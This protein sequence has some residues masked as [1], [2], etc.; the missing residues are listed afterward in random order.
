M[1]RLPL[2]IDSPA[3]T[4]HPSP[5]TLSRMY[6][7]RL[8]DIYKSLPSIDTSTQL[9][10]FLKVPEFCNGFLRALAAQYLQ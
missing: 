1:R 9:F 4:S 6:E 2:A 5:Y 8:F 10:F 3:I 7:L